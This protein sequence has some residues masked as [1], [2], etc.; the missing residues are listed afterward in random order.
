MV[1]EER[2]GDGGGGALWSPCVMWLVASLPIS[3]RKGVCLCLPVGPLLCVFLVKGGK[4]GWGGGVGRHLVVSLLDAVGGE[5][6]GAR[7]A[8]DGRAERRE[9]GRLSATRKGRLR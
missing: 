6:A 4:L 7:D 9:V 2:R 5:G 8:Q 3:G 1:V